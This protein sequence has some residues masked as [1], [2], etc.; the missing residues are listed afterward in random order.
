MN[1]QIERDPIDGFVLSP[2]GWTREWS[3]RESGD[4]EESTN[5]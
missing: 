2:Y 1:E 5:K 3:T 4:S